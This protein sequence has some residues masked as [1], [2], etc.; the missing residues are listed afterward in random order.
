MQ[1]NQVKK[2]SDLTLFIA[3]KE[4]A[5]GFAYKYGGQNNKLQRVYNLISKHPTYVELLELP[6]VREI[7]EN[8]GL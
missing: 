5:A 1:E 8:Y 6:L 3:Q 2:L 4:E 7:L